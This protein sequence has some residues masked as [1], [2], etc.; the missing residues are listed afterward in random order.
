MFDQTEFIK[1]II[2]KIKINSLPLSVTI[3]LNE[4]ELQTNELLGKFQNVLLRTS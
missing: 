1:E 3:Y 2:S 4:E